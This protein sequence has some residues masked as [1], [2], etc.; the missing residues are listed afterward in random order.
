MDHVHVPIKL[1]VPKDVVDF[2]KEDAKRRN[3]IA[4]AGGDEQ[5]WTWKQLAWVRCSIMLGEWVTEQKFRQS[6]EQERRK[7]APA[8][9]SGA[10]A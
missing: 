5:H 4:A 10:T 3:A 8:D 7:D 6:Q 9:E 1:F 2:L